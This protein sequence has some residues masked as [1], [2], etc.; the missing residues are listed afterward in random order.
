[1][2]WKL[3]LLFGLTKRGKSNIWTTQFGLVD[4]IIGNYPPFYC[5]SSFKAS[6]NSENVPA[7]VNQRLL[8]FAK[9]LLL[10]YFWNAIFK[11]FSKWRD[12]DRELSVTLSDNMT[13]N[14]PHTRDVITR[15]FLEGKLLSLVLI[16]EICKDRNQFSL[17]IPKISCVRQFLAALINNDFFKPILQWLETGLTCYVATRFTLSFRSYKDGSSRIFFL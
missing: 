8:S 10:Y 3:S 16:L 14:W 7:V 17:K 13:K 11:K 12:R 6:E 15:H 9:S 5:K 4:S 2:S 1:M